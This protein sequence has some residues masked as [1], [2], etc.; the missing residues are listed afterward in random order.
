MYT[1]RCTQKL[2]KRLGAKR[3]V[4]T[5]PSTALGDW[6]A[7]LLRFGSTQMVL[8]TSERSLLSVVLPARGLKTGL[9]NSLSDGVAAVL[10]GIGA[11]R[12]CIDQELRHMQE[13][14]VAGTESRVV[15]GSMNDF[16]VA[17]DHSL[18]SGP[19]V[20]SLRELSIWLAGTLCG[21]LEYERPGDVARRLLEL[22]REQSNNEMQ[23]TRPG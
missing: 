7:N 20:P 8:C 9:A 17:I 23:W 6:Y 1:I 2:L 18:H 12:A 13:H 15:L 3:G 10:A 11:P 16:A 19:R 22:E 4:A 21:P 14:A 5:A